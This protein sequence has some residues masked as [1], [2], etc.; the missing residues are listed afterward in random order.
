MNLF[1]PKTFDWSKDCRVCYHRVLLVAKPP[2]LPYHKLCPNKPKPKDQD[3][4]CLWEA[5]KPPP[6]QLKLK[7]LHYFVKHSAMLNKFF[8]PGER[9]MKYAQKEVKPPNAN[10]VEA[11]HAGVLVFDIYENGKLCVK[12]FL[13]TETQSIAVLNPY[14]KWNL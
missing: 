7:L 13:V 12:E 2:H 6:E 3:I 14:F 9:A 1:G 10:P 5:Q 11:E 4:I 8:M